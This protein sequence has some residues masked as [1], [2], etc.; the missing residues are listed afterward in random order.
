[1]FSCVYCTVRSQIS[2]S[3]NTQLFTLLQTP[4]FKGDD[5]RVDTHKVKA[6]RARLWLYNKP[7]GELVTHKDPLSR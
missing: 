6:S 4:L 7:R 5:V 2:K 1:M 3:I